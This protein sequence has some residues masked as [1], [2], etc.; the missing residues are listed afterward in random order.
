[1]KKEWSFSRERPCIFAHSTTA[2]KR[3]FS[4]VEWPWRWWRVCKRGRTL[5]QQERPRRWRKR[6]IMVSS[7]GTEQRGRPR[8]ITRV[9]LGMPGGAEGSWPLHPADSLLLLLPR[10]PRSSH[11]TPPPYQGGHRDPWARGQMDPFL[12]LLLLPRPPPCSRPSKPYLQ[13]G[14]VKWEWGGGEG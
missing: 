2:W 9:P 10:G 8:G 4:S 5:Y 6:I 11:Q 1:M 7:S 3:W 13:I 12:R 14:R